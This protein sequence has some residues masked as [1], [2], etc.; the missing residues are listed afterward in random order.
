[1]TEE[2]AKLGLQLNHSKS[3]IIS[4]DARALAAM[5]EVVPDLCPVTPENAHLLGSP[6]GGEEGI[7]GSI[8][9]KITA[10]ETMGNRLCHLRAHDA[11]CLLCHSFALPK[12][13][14]I[15]RTSPCSK[16]PKLRRFDLLLRSLL[17]EIAN[18]N[19]ADNDIA[20]A[21]ASLPVGSGGL[22]VRSA[23]QLAPS[24]FLASAAGCA[25]I[26]QELLPPRLRDTAYHARDDTLQVWREGLDVPPPLAADASRQKAWDAPRVAAS[27][28]ALQEATQDTPAQARLLAASRKE[29]GAWLQTLP[30]SSLGLCMEDDV[31]RVAT[32]LRLGVPICQP[33]KCQLCGSPVDRQGTH[34]L[35]CRKSLGRHPRH[36]AIN[37]LIKRSL[38][39]AKIPAHLEPAGICRSDG[40][41][42]D[43][44]TVLPWRSGR[45]LV[46]DATC[47]DTFA[48]SHRD[49]ATRGAGAVADQAEERKKAKYSELATTHHFVP[50]AVETTGVFGS[51]AQMFFRELGRRI[52][53]ESGEPLAYQYLLQ[54]ISV[55]VQ[56]GNAAAVLGTS[57]P[58]EFDFIYTQ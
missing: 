2:A 34:G 16:S 15:L 3:E 1:M 53:D 41:R 36:S 55:A 27:F 14:Y 25:S 7:D 29:S 42:P 33:H 57:S 37:D 44:A 56:Q 52:R 26:T 46:W 39:S 48:P 58:T 10:L 49:L 5:T 35:H 11:Y 18:I 40:K 51:E 28:K 22:G 13:L 30:V 8:G 6:I 19:I 50:L 9:E 17:G 31:F 47:P 43:G 12:L 20:W 23:T 32:G 54:R 21:Q 38:G 45:I 24:A 4:S